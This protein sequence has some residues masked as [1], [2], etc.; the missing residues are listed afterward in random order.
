[1]IDSE[2][3]VTV[4]HRLAEYLCKQYASQCMDI[5]SWDDWIIRS[6]QSLQSNPIIINK[7]QEKIIIKQII[8]SISSSDLLLNID[9]M[10]E[11]IQQAWQLMRQW[12]LSC[13]GVG[14]QIS[15]DT[16]YFINI[17]KIY[18]DF[19]I[20]N[21]YIDSSYVATALRDL[22]KNQ[23]VKLSKSITFVG[24]NR[25][26]PQAIKLINELK[27]LVKIVF[28]ENTSLESMPQRISCV[29]Q[30]QEI[31]TMARWAQ[32]KLLKQPNQTIGCVIPNLPMLRETI[33]R[34]FNEVFHPENTTSFQ[35]GLNH[36]WNFSVGKI[37]R[38]YPLVDS[39][40][41]LLRLGLTQSANFAQ[42]TSLL[43]SP[44]LGGSEMEFVA[45]AMLGNQLQAMGE[46]EI[47]LRTVLSLAR[48]SATTAHCPKL[49]TI[50]QKLLEILKN[51]PQRQLPSAWASLFKSQLQILGW[52]GE[53]SLNSEEY[54]TS[55]KWQELLQEFANLDHI[56]GELEFSTALELLEQLANSIIFQPE[57]P[58]AR[59]QILG[60]LEATNLQFDHLWI[61]N[62]TDELWPPAPAPNPYLPLELQQRLGMPQASAEQ[63]LE[64]YKNLLERFCQSSKSVICSYPLRE[65]DK[66]LRPSPLI[67]AFPEI[68]EAEL[69][70]SAWTSVDQLIFAQRDIETIEDYQAPTL[71][72]QEI[73]LGGS[74][75]F[76]SQAACPFSAFAKFRLAA[77]NVLR[78]QLG[79]NYIERGILLHTALEKIWN[80][81]GN[82]Y[83]LKTH[84]PDVLEKTILAGIDHALLEQT[85]RKP[86]TLKKYF[87]QTER[88]RL[89]ILITKW[90]AEESKR[91][92]FTVV[93]KEQSQKIK[94]GDLPVKIRVDRIDQLEDGTHIIIDYKTGKTSINDWFGPRPDE[95][96][97]PLYCIASDKSISGLSFAQVRI[98]DVR[99]NGINI[100]DTP[101]WQTLVNEWKI[102][103]NQLANEFCSG[104]ATVTPKDIKKTCQYCDLKPLCR[105]YE[106]K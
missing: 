52:P 41:Q 27:Q 21:H 9:A 49:A 81:L 36:L 35:S 68:S 90:L 92:F 99:F 101:Q 30:Q 88:Q 95:P 34:I 103:L 44:F 85:Q 93:A 72:S 86:L 64:F 79:L 59:I 46:L 25:F 29:S 78:P 82:Q 80:T 1:M 84:N 102:V 60:A 74:G 48:D 73:I 5:L 45:R 91:S 61:M 89:K 38:A 31:Y 67:T 63:E 50:L 55:Q 97:L 54:Q 76:A 23:K 2:V 26:F 43:R 19:L 3:I 24:F 17:Y 37:L 57:T 106:R 77:E 104:N 18:N 47:N 69:D 22:L 62:L 100:S 98:D 15:I 105:I 39:A 58:F 11:V 33:E 12:E 8:K 40:L 32:Q 16:L 53:R 87:T 66:T 94:I 28:L 75:I 7:F 4:N 13:E 71:Q 70:L 42:I 83:A 20:K 65:A 14:Q 51:L 96:Q 10:V 56:S 6:W